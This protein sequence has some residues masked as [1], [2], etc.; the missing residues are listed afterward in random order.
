MNTVF[1]GIKTLNGIERHRT[2][3]S[4]PPPMLKKGTYKVFSILIY[5]KCE[6]AREMQRTVAKRLGIWYKDLSE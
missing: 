1:S 5:S 4:S 2:V 3:P 6:V